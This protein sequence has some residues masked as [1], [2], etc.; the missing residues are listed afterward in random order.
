MGKSK[1][2]QK[3]TLNINAFL[4]NIGKYVHFNHYKPIFCNKCYFHSLLL[5]FLVFDYNVNFFL[6]SFY[7]ILLL[8]EM[9]I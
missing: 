5:F 3:K 2:K 9:F 4:R 7:F 8:F 6:Y 1:S